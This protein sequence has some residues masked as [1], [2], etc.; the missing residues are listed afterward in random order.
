M[1]SAGHYGQNSE[2][3]PGKNSYEL[4]VDGINKVR[5]ILGPD[6]VSAIMTTTSRSLNR[7]K[8]IIDEYL[9]QSFN[10]IFLR[11]L[12]PYGFAI[13]TKAFYSYQTDEWLNFYKTGLD[14]II[15]INKKGVFFY[16]AI[17]INYIEQNAI[18]AWQ[19]L[20]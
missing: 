20:C 9:Y 17:C 15:E 6:K 1:A 11:S 19:Y 5:S 10:S 8:E 3:R 16:R 14:Y 4:T 13:K 2:G 18:S 12:S 7:V